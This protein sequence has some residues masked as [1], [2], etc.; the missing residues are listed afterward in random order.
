MKTKEQILNEIQECKEE[1]KLE[2]SSGKIDYPT[3]ATIKYYL[4][5]LYDF[6]SIEEDKKTNTIE[7]VLGI[8]KIKSLEQIKEYINKEFYAAGKAKK[9]KRCDKED[10]IYLSACEDQCAAILDFIQKEENEKD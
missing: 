5:R 2:F 3:S 1:N 4:C 10:Y 8:Y 6:V 7:Q 9:L